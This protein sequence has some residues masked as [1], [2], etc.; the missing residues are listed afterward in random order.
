MPEIIKLC[1]NLIASENSPFTHAIP[2]LR[3]LVAD[4]FLNR[5]SSSSPL[6]GPG[7][8]GGGGVDESK[9][10]ELQ[11]DVLLVTLIRLV[12]YPAI[13]PLLSLVVA[14]HKRDQADKWR[15]VS[16][17]ICDAL[18]D[19]MRSPMSRSLSSHH[20]HHQHQHQHQHHH[21]HQHV[22]RFADHDG[23]ELR[24]VRRYSRAHLPHVASLRQLLLL[25]DTLAPQVF[26]PIDF[27][28]LSMFET[29]QSYM[30]HHQHHQHHPPPPAHSTSQLNDWLCIVLAHLH[31]LLTHSSE[32]QVLGRIHHLMPHLV[33]TLCMPVDNGE[34]ATGGGGET[35]QGENE[36]HGHDGDNDENDDEQ[37]DGVESRN[38]GG[39]ADAE[40]L[41]HEDDELMRLRKSSVSESTTGSF[42]LPSVNHTVDT[43]VSLPRIVSIP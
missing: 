34:C 39:D 19:A 3:P 12:A 27:I 20:A 36:D 37:H 30:I 28:L 43:V 25:L 5:H 31:L 17:Q 29:S 22:L 9:E 16:R 33:A 18:F 32:Q 23:H 2:A 35:D 40:S 6:S 41:N 8:G 24:C 42:D 21:H 13:W 14:K 10:L 7:G 1:D 26:R 15:R 4:L 11:Q 38:G